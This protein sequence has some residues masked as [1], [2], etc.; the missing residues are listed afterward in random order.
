[1]ETQI[2]S[3]YRGY[4]NAHFIGDVC[5]HLLTHKLPLIA[6]GFHWCVNICRQ[7]D[8]HRMNQNTGE[9]GKKPLGCEKSN[10]TETIVVSASKTGP[11]S[12]KMHETD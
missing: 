8:T 6:A 1:M 9:W 11:V 3:A 2:P 4:R 7:S 10:K 5:L 12:V